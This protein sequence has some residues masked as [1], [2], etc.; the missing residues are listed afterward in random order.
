MP[1]KDKLYVNVAWDLPLPI[2]SGSSL[3]HADI[4]LEM[5]ITLTLDKSDPV[6]SVT[7]KKSLGEVTFNATTKL[8]HINENKIT[9]PGHYKIKFEYTDVGGEPRRGD[10]CNKDNNTDYLTFYE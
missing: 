1:C 10:G 6:V 5:T 4:G 9:V 7:F 3:S 2:K 8:L